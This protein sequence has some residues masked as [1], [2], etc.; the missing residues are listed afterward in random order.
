MAF[1]IVIRIDVYQKKN[2]HITAFLKKRM[3]LQKSQKYE[4]NQYPIETIL[5]W[6]KSEELAIPEIQRPFVWSSTQV[7]KLIRS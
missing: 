5:N 4:V 6:Y 2:I 7:R 1:S 3:A